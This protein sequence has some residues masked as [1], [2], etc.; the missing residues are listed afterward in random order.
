MPK[1]FDNWGEEFV[2]SF[3]LYPFDHPPGVTNILHIYDYGAEYY[4]S[5]APDYEDYGAQ[6]PG[7][8]T[9]QPQNIQYGSTSCVVFKGGIQNQKDFWLKINC[10]QMKL[11]IKN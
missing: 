7:Y 8:K 11:L 6:I 9:I 4:Y 3:D 2:I 10:S 5:Y 1:I